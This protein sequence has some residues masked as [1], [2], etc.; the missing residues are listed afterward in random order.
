MKS[1]FA[2]S[3][4]EKLKSLDDQEIDLFFLTKPAFSPLS[5]MPGKGLQTQI[6]PST[7]GANQQVR[8]S[9]KGVFRYRIQEKAF[10]TPD[11]I[12]FFDQFT[13][14]KKIRIMPPHTALELNQSCTKAAI[15][16]I[17]NELN[18]IEM[19]WRKMK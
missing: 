2:S 9:R 17:P 6:I 5:L 11:I 10:Q 18:Y 14:K 7:K 12:E 3:K 19:L 15:Y 4:L 13:P 16:S 1:F 8:D